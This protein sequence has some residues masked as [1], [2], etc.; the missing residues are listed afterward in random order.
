MNVYTVLK[1]ARILLALLYNIY[2]LKFGFHT[3]AATYKKGETIHKTIKKTQNT[4]NRQQK[5]TTKNKNEKNIT[6]YKSSN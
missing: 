2:L 6:K 4:Q 5:Y 3:V 1:H